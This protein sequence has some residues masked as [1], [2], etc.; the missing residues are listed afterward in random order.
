M[1]NRSHIGHMVSMKPFLTLI[2][3]FFGPSPSAFS[4]KKSKIIT[5]DVTVRTRDM[6]IIC[7]DRVSV[8]L[9]NDAFFKWHMPLSG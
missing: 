6:K 9:Y 8:R 4:E 1:H 7:A 3:E 5:G 2:R